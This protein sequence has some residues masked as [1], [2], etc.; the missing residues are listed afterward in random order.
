MLGFGKVTPEGRRPTCGPRRG[1]RG[2][3]VEAGLL[4]LGRARGVELE[5]RRLICRAPF[6]RSGAA[7][8]PAAPKQ[9]GRAWSRG[10]DGDSR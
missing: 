1:C 9:R 10:P 8:S 4:E 2:F 6:R 5:G 3:D 7:R